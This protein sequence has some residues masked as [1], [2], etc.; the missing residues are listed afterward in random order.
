MTDIITD[1]TIIDMDNKMTDNTTS[2]EYKSYNIYSFVSNAVLYSLYSVIGVVSFLYGIDNIS[3]DND[4]LLSLSKLL[5]AFGVLDFLFGIFL[6]IY[7]IAIIR[8]N[9]Y[10]ANKISMFLFLII[11]LLF[12]FS[13]MGFL[14]IYKYSKQNN[15]NYTAKIILKI[16][17]YVNLIISSI[18]IIFNLICGVIMTEENGFFAGSHCGDDD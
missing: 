16:N 18:V 11:V 5:I 10:C 2:N 17:M 12:I 14:Q 3:A 7:R 8:K 6:T 1:K 13:V 15:L 9:D 4:G